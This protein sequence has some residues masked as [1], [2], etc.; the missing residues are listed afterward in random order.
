MTAYFIAARPEP[1]VD[2]AARLFPPTRR[3]AARRVL[4]RL[5]GVMLGSMR[6]VRTVHLHRAVIASGGVAVGAT[7]G[8]IGPLVAIP[9]LATVIILV[10]EVSAKPRE[11]QLVVAVEP[12][13]LPRSG[14]RVT[15]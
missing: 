8:F 10:E 15:A 11:P 13:E 7:F 14:P 1:L 9:I 5:R 2:G 4:T 3:A 12:S 6:G